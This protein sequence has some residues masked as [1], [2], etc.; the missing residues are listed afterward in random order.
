MN[1]LSRTRE[2]RLL[3]M[4]AAATLCLACGGGGPDSPTTPTATSL[5]ELEFLSFDLANSARRDNNVQPMLELDELVAVV[6]RAHSESMRDEGFFGHR[7]SHGGLSDRLRSAGVSFSHAGETL[8]MVE[9]VPDPAGFAHSQFL[10]S[11]DH[12]AIMLDRRYRLAGVGVARDGDTYWFT[13]I[14]IRR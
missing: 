12:R 3:A 8:A 5:A 10:D 2:C 4:A 7:G 13:Q 11:E 1:Q 14:Y 9:G 6:A